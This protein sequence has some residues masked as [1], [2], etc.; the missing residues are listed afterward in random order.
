M[1]TAVE[2]AVQDVA[3]AQVALA[4]GAD[5]VEL[6]Q[7]LGATGGLTPSAALI[8]A[9]TATGIAVHVL[10]RSRPGG[11]VYPTAE[12]DLMARE[13]ELTIAAGASGVVIGALAADGTLDSGAMRT[14]ITAAHEARGV[15]ATPPVE[16]TCHRAFDVVP[17]RLRAL[18]TLAELGVTRVLTSGGAPNVGAGLDALAQLVRHDSGV[19]IMA[20]GGVRVEGIPGLIGL[21]VHAVHLSAKKIVTDPGASGPGGGAG[22]GLEVTDADVVRAAIESARAAH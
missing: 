20:G 4:A 7:A 19:Q 15:G 21:G 18:D 11:F 14:L 5:R 22:G 10:I 17:D 2:I 16:V 3:G 9:V 8:E 12:I 1:P 13:I 6:C